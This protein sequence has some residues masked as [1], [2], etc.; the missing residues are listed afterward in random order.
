[1][2][3]NRELLFGVFRLIILKC[4]ELKK[5][6]VF[7]VGM[8]LRLMIW[9]E[10]FLGFKESIFLR[11]FYHFNPLLCYKHIE[12]VKPHFIRVECDIP[13]FLTYLFLCNKIYFIDFIFYLHYSHVWWSIYTFWVVS[14]Y[15]IFFL[16]SMHE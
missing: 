1:M 14:N 11:P 13:K 16:K 2:E 12:V 9:V 5:R 7:G 15:W 3:K 10:V 4:W 6:R 8:Q